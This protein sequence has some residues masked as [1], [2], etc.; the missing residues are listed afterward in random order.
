M[1]KN[2]LISSKEL[3]GV[4]IN[5]CKGVK[6]LMSSFKKW[7]YAEDSS[8]DED[9]GNGEKIF[10]EV[11]GEPV[12]SLDAFISY[13]ILNKNISGTVK[14]KN[15]S[16][17]VSLLSLS[18][19]KKINFLVKKVKNIKDVAEEYNTKFGSVDK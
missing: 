1:A 12:Q 13:L 17:P 11:V 16:K 18:E 9:L 15:K 8:K 5:R 2:I 14:L 4:S 19:E 7:Y 3:A 10:L 6:P